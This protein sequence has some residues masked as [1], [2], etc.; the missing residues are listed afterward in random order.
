[1]LSFIRAAVF[2]ASLQSNRTLSETD[3]VMVEILDAQSI[4]QMLMAWLPVYDS[5]KRQSLG[6]RAS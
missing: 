5:G 6:G 1:M 4:A 2:V 3:G